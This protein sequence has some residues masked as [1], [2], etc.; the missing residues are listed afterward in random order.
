MTFLEGKLF[1][2]VKLYNSLIPLSLAYFITASAPSV[3]RPFP[4][5]SELA[6]NLFHKTVT[7]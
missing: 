5:T 1:S 3:A 2:E 4:H 6:S 7:L